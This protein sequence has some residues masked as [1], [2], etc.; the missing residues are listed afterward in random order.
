MMLLADSEGVHSQRP[1]DTGI[2]TQECYLT[3]QKTAGSHLIQLD[4]P[5]QF[6]VLEHTYMIYDIYIKYKI[7][8]VTIICH[9]IY[10]K[11]IL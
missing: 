2:T 5:R 6:K 8:T 11:L 4:S 9:I 3:S 10:I 1:L 7:Y